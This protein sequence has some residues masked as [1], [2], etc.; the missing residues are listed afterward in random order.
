[1]EREAGQ[2]TQ[3]QK[4]DNEKGREDAMKQFS[5]RHFPGRKMAH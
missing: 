5:G 2:A 3:T 4:T 1:M